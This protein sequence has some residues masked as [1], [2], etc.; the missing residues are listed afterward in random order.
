MSQVNIKKDPHDTDMA[1]VYVVLKPG[2]RSGRAR[3]LCCCS[4][5]VDAIFDVFGGEVSEALG[6][7]GMVDVNVSAEIQ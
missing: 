6:E 5:H 2:P 4:M 7:Q 1:Q 3:W